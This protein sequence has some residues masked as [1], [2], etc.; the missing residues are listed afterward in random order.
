MAQRAVLLVNL[1]SPDSPTVPDVRRYLSEFLGDERVID[2]PGWPWRWLLVNW[3]IIP[4]RVANS[5]HAYKKVWTRLGSPL[6]VTSEIV[7][8]KLVAALAADEVPVF[9]AMRY[10]APAIATVL[11][12]MAKAGVEDV[13]LFPQYPHYAMSSYETVVEKVFAEARRMEWSPRFTLVQPFFEDP[14]Y[15]AALL[16][17]ARPALLQDHDHLLF[18]YHGLPERHMRKA[19]SSH[20]HCLTAPDCC[21]TCAPAHATC[22]RAQTVR[23]TQ[24][25]ARLAGLNPAKFS[26][27][28]QSRLAGEP[29]LTPYTDHELVRLPQEGRKK[30]VVITP[31]FTADC[32]ETLEEIRL[33]GRDMFL[34]A[35]GESFTHIPCLN[36]HPAFI[37][38]L[39]N[40]T[41]EWLAGGP[42]R[43][44]G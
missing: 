22:Y 19:D 20:A 38:Y 39:A 30:L 8:K 11:A 43:M 34:A 23:T 16:E 35:G 4:R 5:A 9:L 32:L 36:D 44:G 18:S 7:Q 10:G 33:A 6:V 26:I 27:S 29:W 15:I 3:L 17:S 42:E 14:G 28:Y 31:A 2:R 21:A 1:G 37:A 24:A 40:R 12:A 25:F 41:R 13:L